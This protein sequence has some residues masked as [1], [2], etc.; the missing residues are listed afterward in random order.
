MDEQLSYGLTV[1]GLGF[2]GWPE[3]METEEGTGK[4]LI[5]NTPTA[6]EVQKL[7]ATGKGFVGG[8]VLEIY[9]AGEELP[10]ITVTTESEAAVI[11]SLPAGEYILHEKTAPLGYRKAADVTFSVSD[12][13]QD[14][15]E[16]GG[17]EWVQKVVMYDE[18]ETPVLSPKTADAFARVLFILLPL[19]LL[20]A[21]LGFIGLRRIK[22]TVRQTG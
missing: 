21:G 11:H 17:T 20:G 22:K 3:D 5:Y 16:A 1:D 14:G 10:A 9:R 6:V 18:R 7:D 12:Q 4:I 19:A 13:I 8:A 15:T 2:V